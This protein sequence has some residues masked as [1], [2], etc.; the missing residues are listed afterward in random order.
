LLGQHGFS[1][2]SGDP[3]HIQMPSAATGGI[4]SGP[5]SGYQAMLHGNEAVVPLPDGKTIPLKNN[6]AGGS[7]EQTMLLSMELEKLDSMLAVMQKQTDITTR[8]LAKQS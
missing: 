2:L 6:N 7:K 3:P 5:I 1:T 8:I 4:L